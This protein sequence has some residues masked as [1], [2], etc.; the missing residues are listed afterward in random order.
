MAE[1]RCD[2]IGTPIPHTVKEA[3]QV[4]SATGMDACSMGTVE[5][6]SPTRP[7]TPGRSFFVLVAFLSACVEA[8]TV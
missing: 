6:P 8:N 7:R 5:R 3:L 1:T 2:R 4:V